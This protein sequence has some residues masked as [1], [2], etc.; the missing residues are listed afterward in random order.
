M[1]RLS[2]AVVT[3]NRSMTLLTGRGRVEKSAV[4]DTVEEVFKKGMIMG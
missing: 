2:L 1:V 3:C 4:E